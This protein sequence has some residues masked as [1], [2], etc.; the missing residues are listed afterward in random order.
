MEEDRNH[1]TTIPECEKIEEAGQEREEDQVIS[2]EC[3]QAREEASHKK[4]IKEIMG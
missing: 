1:L 2:P 4:E 3:E